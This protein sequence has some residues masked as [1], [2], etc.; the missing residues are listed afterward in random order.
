M[1]WAG[2]PHPSAYAAALKSTTELRG[3]EPE[4]ARI[5]AIGDSLR[6]DL[7]AAQG[8][9]VDAL[10]IAAGIHSEVIVDGAIDPDRLAAL[11]APART[12]PAIAAMM[13]LWW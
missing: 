3:A 2:K 11:F 4:R 5:L 10:F 13:E 1:F 8:M 7:A 9:G 12:P 6:T